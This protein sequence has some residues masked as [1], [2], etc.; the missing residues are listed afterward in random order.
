MSAR[1]QKAAVE[2]SKIVGDDDEEE[3]VGAHTPDSHD[4]CRWHFP[5]PTSG[6]GKVIPLF[7]LGWLLDSRQL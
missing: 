1:T 3:A 6:A 5:S 4:R 7:N 2:E